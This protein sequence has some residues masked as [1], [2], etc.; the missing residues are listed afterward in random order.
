MNV[1][2]RSTFALNQF[3]RT[4]EIEWQQLHEPGVTGVFGKV[5]RY[6]EATRRAPTILLKFDAGATYPAHN[7]PGGEEIFVLEGDIRLGKDTLR[8]GDYLYT[9]PNNKH[10]VAS[11]R[12]CIVL[13][14][15]PQQVEILTF[16][17][18]RGDEAGNIATPSSTAE[19]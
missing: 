15:V 5:L 9:A 1:P 8:K 6:D 16:G 4:D 7:H 11:E 14:N 13:A 17:P 12:G 19:T 2:V 3:V 10:A 18:A